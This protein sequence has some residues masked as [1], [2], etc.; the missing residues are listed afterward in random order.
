MTPHPAPSDDPL[1]RL[2]LGNLDRQAASVDAQTLLAAIK[3]RPTAGE[4]VHSRRTWLKR[5][6]AGAGLAVAASAAG[7][8]LLSGESPIEPR[9]LSA[10]EWI[11]QAKVTHEKSVDRGYEVTADWDL[12]PFKRFFPFRP[13]TRNFRLWTRGDQFFVRVGEGATTWTWGQERSGKI[14]IALNRQ[15]ALIYEPEEI[16]D[17]LARYCELI[18]LRIVTL[19]EELLDR[20]DLAQVAPAAPGEPRRIHAT[21]KPTAQVMPRFRSLDLVIDEQTNVLQSLTLQRQYQGEP[22]GELQFTL[23]DTAPQPDSAYTLA[24]H[25][26]PGAQIH[27]APPL[28]AGPPQKFAPKLPQRP[29]LDEARK[30]VRD[31]LIRRWQNRP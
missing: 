5:A 17:P 13:P 31:E 9:E 20:Y 27:E 4:P 19:L 21:W 14:W 2:I 23:V 12:A 7:W 3:A 18:S 26:E 29:P 6:L 25:I 30:R 15:R 1:D 28:P 10:R 11:T 22:L 24:G 8:L 16:Q